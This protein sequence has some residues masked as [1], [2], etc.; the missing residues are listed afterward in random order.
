RNVSRRHARIVRQTGA[1]YIEDLQSYNGIKVNNEKISGKAP[2]GDG[3]VIV[4]GDYR[5]SIK[6]EKADAKAAASI[7]PTPSSPGIAASPPAMTVP[8]P[9]IQQSS[10]PTVQHQAMAPT[11]APVKGPEKPARLI[12]I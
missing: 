11:A 1:L 6:Q 7:V 10:V 8:A 9:A 12:V 5:L 2:I 3:D 4:I